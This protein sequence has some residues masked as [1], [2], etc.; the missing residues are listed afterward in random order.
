MLGLATV[1]AIAVV[2]IGIKFVHGELHFA[3]DRAGI[4]VFAGLAILFRQAEMAGRKHKLNLA[5]HSYYRENADG[6]INVVNAD[7]INEG[8]VEARTNGIGNS[9][10]AHAAVAEFSA[11]L[12]KL[13]VEANGRCNLND[14]GGQGGLAVATE[15]V[16]IEAEAVVFGIGSEH[17]DV[18][19]AAVKNDLL[20]EGAKPLNL[21]HSAAANTSLESYTEIITDSY[22]IKALV[23]GYGLDIDVGVDNL[24][25][26]TSYRACLIDNLL[27]HVA[28]MHLYVLETILIAR[29]IENFIYADAAKLFLLSAKPAEQAVSFIH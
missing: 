25:A 5:F 2:G 21:L 4:I 18:L 1:G 28:K 16:L 20:I 24:N 3:E 11:T 10:D 17:R 22:L 15:I 23:E 6:N 7:A 13:A 14:N 27:R 26:L 8:A 12:Y 9:I 19:F 29:G